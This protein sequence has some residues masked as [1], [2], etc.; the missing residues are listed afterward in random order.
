MIKVP[1]KLLPYIDF[2][3]GEIISKDLP[4]DLKKEFEEFKESIETLKKEN[5]LSDF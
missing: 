1:E 3:D 5:P 2:D 4:S